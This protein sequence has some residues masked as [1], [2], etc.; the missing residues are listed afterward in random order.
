[1]SNFSQPETLLSASPDELTATLETVKNPIL[2]AAVLLRLGRLEEAH[3]LVQSI[4]GPVAAYWHGIM[5]RLEGD[6]W[7][8]KYWFR[9]ANPIPK[10]I[11][12]DPAKL[13]DDYE[14]NRG[15]PSAEL[16]TALDDE[17]VRLVRHTLAAT[18]SVT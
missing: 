6:Y 2:R 12:S 17:W 8:A 3:Q 14:A 18:T 16:K 7:N 11:G 1:M 15:E 9:Q 4:E 13:T 10:A 5:H